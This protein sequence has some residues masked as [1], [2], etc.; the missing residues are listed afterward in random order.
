APK[1]VA[2][3]NGN[4]TNIF[5]WETDASGKDYKQFLASFLPELI[6]Y[7][8]EHNL[9][10]KVYFHV[11]DEPNI[12]H[13]D[14]YKNAHDIIH[15]YLGEFPV[16]DALSDYAF[17]E[18]GLVENP[19]PGTNHIEPF[20][21]N[22]VENLWTYYCC[23]QYKRVSNRFFSFPSARNRMIGMQLY[24]YDIKGFLQWGY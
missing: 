15:H 4:E 5:G 16:I 13:L 7:I 6:A 9:E 19:I 8:K 22:G 18:R 3:V 23:A 20:L 1:I 24:K 17:Y 14:S 11:S 12:N 2:K 21:E 10:D